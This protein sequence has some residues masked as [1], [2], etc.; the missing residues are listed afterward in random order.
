MKLKVHIAHLQSL[1]CYVLSLRV[2]LVRS[3]QALMI[4]AGRSMP[5]IERRFSHVLALLLGAVLVA[6]A[7]ALE[8]IESAA[9][10]ERIELLFA[11]IAN[12]VADAPLITAA[13]LAEKIAAH[14]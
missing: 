14:T 8:P 10:N 5:S 6:P 13:V 3:S 1:L 2:L 7:V 11:E 4:S 9:L 12:K